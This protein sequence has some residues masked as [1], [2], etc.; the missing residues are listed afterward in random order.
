MSLKNAFKFII[1]K[2]GFPAVFTKLDDESEREYFIDIAKSN[3]DRKRDTV[4]QVTYSGNE[5]VVD[6]DDLRAVDYPLPVE[7]G[8]QIRSDFFGTDS[9]THVNPQIVMGELIGYRITV[10]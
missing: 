4:E 2:A 3:R 9:I 10:G 6:I 7:V 5:F 1:N 8:D